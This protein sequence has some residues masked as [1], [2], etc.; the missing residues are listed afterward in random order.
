[1]KSVRL[2]INGI[3]RQF[4][5]EEDLALLDLLRQDLRLTGAKQSC[6][7]KG[8]CGACTVI[9]NGKASRSCLLKVESLNG[10]EIL[11]VEGLGTPQNP[12][13][14]QEAFVLAGA[15]QCGYCTPGLIMATKALLDENP[16]P[17]RDEIKRA[18]QRNLCRCTGYTRIIEAVELAARFLRGDTTP[19]AM[20]PKPDAGQIGVSHPRPWSMLKACGLAEFTADIAVPGALELAVV[21]SP[22]HNAKIKHIDCSA[23][24][25]MPGVVG[26]MTAKDIRGTNS[27]GIAFKDQPLLC[28]ELAPVLGSPVAIVAAETKK[29]ALAAVQEVHVEYE[30][31]PRIATPEEALAE[32]AL[33]VHPGTA[34]L[35]HSRRQIKGDAETALN[36][37]AAV[38]SAEFYSQL[39]HQAPLEP[40]A[41]VAYLE[42]QGEDAQLVII[43]RSIWI[44]THAQVL[45]DTLGWGNIRYEEAFAGGQFGIKVDITSEAI[46]GAAALHFQRP[47]RYIPSLTES[48]WMTTKR[49][50]FR[51]KVRLGSNADGRLTGYNIDFTVENGAYMSIGPEI[52]SRAL[53]MLSGGYHIPNVLAEA[54][55]VYTNNA[56]G[57]AARGAGPPQVN[58]ALESAMD[59]LAAK[60]N[61]D[62]Y[63]FRRINTLQPGQSMSTG[64]VAEEWAFSACLEKIGPIYKR[65]RKEAEAFKAG[66][67]RRGVG[68]AGSSFGI[69]DPSDTSHVAVEL[70]PEG[71]LA[72]YASVADP[73][74]GND[75]MLTQLASH[76]MGIPP[77]KVRLVTRNTEQTP[78]SGISAGSRQTYMSG[79]AMVKAIELLKD[80][81]REC[82]AET[83]EDLVNRAKPTRYM[84]TITLPHTGMDAE[85]GQGEVWESRCHGLQM[86]EVEVNLETGAVRILKMTA[87]V[88]PGTI[89]NPLAVTCQ[90]EGGMDMGAGMALREEYVHG[91][92]VDWVTYRYPTM[93][94]AFDMETILLESPRKRGPLGATGVGEFTLVPTHP[95]IINAIADAAGVRIYDMPA[96]PEKILAALKAGA[97]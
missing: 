13:L 82:G 62:P 78:N 56:W 38:V 96:T 68:L 52:I 32:G 23:A 22:H 4:I 7:R 65:A 5:V 9:V 19:S 51:M 16:N 26:I 14:I 91:E 88:D 89:I 10:A 28:N 90:L 21:R 31:L 87:V 66:P 97:V 58:F 92:T 70:E 33:E 50:P 67:I 57:G 64:H 84:A 25:K 93:K 40:E 53:G 59:L 11:T 55:L 86:A 42:G 54:K 12:H 8:Q 6:D 18:L 44:H 95:A 46:A 69:G 36:D 3:Q 15:I 63:E 17:G 37:S 85:T 60:L 30:V 20:R 81:M 61:M 2:R 49:H 35:C 79:Q 76:V 29:Q 72:V 24:E 27:V 77:E 39:I 45:Q 47:V 73:G 43:G 48:M 94:T 41:A 34:N 71:V 83:R 74:E 1:M 80:A 75:A